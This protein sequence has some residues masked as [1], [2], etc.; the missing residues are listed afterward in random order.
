V[1]IVDTIVN[2][3]ASDS[4][5]DAFV[6]TNWDGVMLGVV[7]ALYSQHSF[8]DDVLVAVMEDDVGLR[9]D[10]MIDGVKMV[11]GRHCCGCNVDTNRA[12]LRQR[13]PLERSTLY[14]LKAAT[15]FPLFR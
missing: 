11:V 4:F 12:A 6:V 9:E 13:Q 7:R 1:G 3:A 10:T 2:D 15:V 8:Q 14:K 5:V